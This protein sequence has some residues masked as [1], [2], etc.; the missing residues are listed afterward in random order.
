MIFNKK[1][2]SNVEPVA[3]WV[4]QRHVHFALL[5]QGYA[6]LHRDSRR[7]QFVHENKEGERDL[8]RE[9]VLAHVVQWKYSISSH[10][11]AVSKHFPQTKRTNMFEKSHTRSCNTLEAPWAAKAATSISPVL[12]PPPNLR[13]SRGCRVN[14]S[15]GP[16]VRT[17][18]FFSAKWI[19][20]A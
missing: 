10:A 2:K 8:A 12:R 5:V 6:Q 19:N 7:F 14:G 16:V 9:D 1:N 17:C 11:S 15:R 18:A 20:L 4:R 3:I 13:P